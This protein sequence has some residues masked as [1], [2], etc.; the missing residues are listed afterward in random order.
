MISCPCRDPHS[1]LAQQLDS[2]VEGEVGGA[3]A[4]GARHPGPREPAGGQACGAGVVR[5]SQAAK[6]SASSAAA[7]AAASRHVAARPQ[8]TLAGG[9]GAAT[10]MALLLMAAAPALLQG[11]PRTLQRRL[12]A[13]RRLAGPCSARLLCVGQVQWQSKG[14]SSERGPSRGEDLRAHRDVSVFICLHIYIYINK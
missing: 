4:G 9:S 11:V 6:P 3:Q 8:C 12:L 13:A 7:S 14:H 1:G 10:P 5:H 2:G